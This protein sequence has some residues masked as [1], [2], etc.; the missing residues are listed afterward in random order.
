MKKRW[1]RGMAATRGGPATHA[2]D[3]LGRFKTRSHYYYSAMTPNRPLMAAFP[4]GLQ[5]SRSTAGHAAVQPLAYAPQGLTCFNG[6]FI[7]LQAFAWSAGG[8][9]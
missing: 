5:A 4:K 2:G 8:T 1:F 7:G 9:S 3:F 6:F